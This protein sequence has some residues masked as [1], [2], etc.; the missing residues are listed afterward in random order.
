ERYKLAFTPGLI[1]QVYRRA[2][3]ALLPDPS[4]VLGGRGADQGGYVDLDGDGH[5]WLP[6]GRTFYAPG[7]A[8]DPAEELAAARSHFF[9]AQR[10]QDPFGQATVLQPDAY[11]LLPVWTRDPLGNVVSAGE[12]NAAGALIGAGIDYRVLQPFLV[13]DANRNRSRVAFD[14]LG[15]VA[16][17]A[18]M[19]KP[20]ESL[21]DDLDDFTS[22]L[23]DV[24]IAAHLAD[25]LAGAAALLGSA[26]TRLVVDLF[27]YRRSQA[28]PNPLPVVVSTVTRAR[29]QSDLAQGESS[30]LE[31]ALAYSDGFDRIIQ[32]KRSAEPGADGKPR[33]ICSG[34]TLYNNKGKPVRKYEPFF[35]ATHRFE[36]ARQV[37]VSPVLLYDPLGRVVAT[38]HPNHAW[39]KEV[40]GAW[41]QESWDAN[42]TV[43]VAEP[44]L[45][46]DVGAAI[47]R[48]PAADVLPTWSQQRLGGALGAAE[49]AA[50]Q[51]AAIHAGTPRTAHLDGLGR[52]YLRVAH[53]RWE[54]GG[55]VFD[56]PVTT[57]EELDIQGN[58][59]AVRDALGRVVMRYDYD[60]LGHRIHQASME[61][62]ER[63]VLND[64]AGN[65]IRVWDSR[66]HTFRTLYDAL[67][68]PTEVYV[69]SDAESE[70]LNERTLYG[71]GQGDA[72]NHRGRVYRH[73]DQVGVVT[74]VAYDF[75]GNLLESTR[76]LAQEATRA[77]DW[78]HAP[79]LETTAFSAGTTYD[80]LNRPVTQ[81]A[82]D[83]S[84]VRRTYNA[85]GLP[86]SVA[87]TRPGASDPTP[88]VSAIDYDA[89]G[90]RTRIAYGN[91]A[92]TTTTYDP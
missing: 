48:L 5:A 11:D 1:E 41:R 27:A 68:R 47:G 40:L 12:R 62:G 21:G 45:D 31:H 66:G 30:R 78:A 3:Q 85:S 61:A 36:F 67:R 50:A 79:A 20:E 43:S 38:L 32:E 29:H 42:D 69:Q 77:L 24:Q 75:K 92:V 22:D 51:K 91:A 80:A 55:Q 6:S 46:P 57:Y 33:W 60:L 10:Y 17:S 35:T 23:T 37:G 9:T 14:V 15:L 54:A 64:V 4:A 2:G 58:T 84:V 72:G 52:P 81:T 39:E 7:P 82:P 25:P 71:E 34:W 13:M 18:V 28:E 70:E 19:G 8:A 87:R 88:L 86:N 63:W 90:R 26:T 76:T 89:K 44:A 53:N 16:G 56:E 59:R 49:A 65:A 74:N 73:F 83:G